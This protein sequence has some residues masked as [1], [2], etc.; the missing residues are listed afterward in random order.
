MV[1]MI[2][3]M[4]KSL[5]VC[6]KQKPRGDWELFAWFIKYIP[7]KAAISVPDTSPWVKPFTLIDMVMGLAKY[8]YN[9]CVNCCMYIASR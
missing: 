4:H 1:C 2:S 8:S 9:G 5:V 7:L 3:T 6:V